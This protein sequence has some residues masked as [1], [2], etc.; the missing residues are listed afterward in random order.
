MSIDQRSGAT[1][2]LSSASGR[3]GGGEA[4]LPA[5]PVATELLVTAYTDANL[6]AGCATGT[7]PRDSLT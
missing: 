6:T 3:A 4:V 1:T 2:A 7:M 5:V